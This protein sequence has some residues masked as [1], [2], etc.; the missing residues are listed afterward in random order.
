MHVYNEAFVYKNYG[1]GQ[2]EA[3]MLFAICAAIGIIQVYF[4][5]KGE[6]EA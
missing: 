4:G 3:L 6:V 2:S 1:V 5:K